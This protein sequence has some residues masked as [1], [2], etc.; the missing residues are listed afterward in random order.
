M[1]LDVPVVGDDFEVAC[2]VDAEFLRSGE[3]EADGFGVGVG[4]DDEVELQLAL[5]AVI[6]EIDAGVDGF[7]ANLAEGGDVAVPLR[8]VLAD[9]VVDVAGEAVFLDKMG[10]GFAGFGLAASVMDSEKT[11]AVSV[12][13]ME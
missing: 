6:D 7:V 4:G 8:G 9:E 2:L 3:V 13:K 10:P 12:R 5:V 1:E 11:A